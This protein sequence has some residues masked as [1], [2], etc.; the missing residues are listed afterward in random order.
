MK[1]LQIYKDYYPVLGGIENHLRVLCEGLCARGHEVTALVTSPGR[2]TTIAQHGQLRIVRA[3]RLL[4]AASTPL[5]L[6]MLREALQAP[7]D[8]VHLHYP[9]PPGDLA[10]LLRPALPLVVTYHSDIVR[11]QRLDRAYAPLRA[12][13][14]RRAQAI[15]ATNAP[16]IASSPVL[17]PLAHKCRVVPLSV[18]A[19]RFATPNLELV[20][21]LRARTAGPVVLFVGRL[22]YYKGL[23]FALEALREVPGTLL[24]V[25]SGGE[26]PRLR[27][28]AAELGIASRVVFA[29]DVDDEELP[30]YYAAA[31]LFVL[32]A[33]LRAEAFGTVL[34]EAMATGLPLLTTELGTGTS[35]VN[36]HGV[37][38]FVVPP[39]DSAALARA[40]AVLLANPSLRAAFGA[41]GKARAA[42][43]FS[44][45]QLIASIEQV[46]C[47][48]LGRQ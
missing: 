5:S 7:A 39:A 42:T 35:Y 41:A 19:G 4:Q 37:T 34:L 11:Q 47:E 46:Y 26:E 3:G 10:A 21:T 24:L 9:F 17:R 8:L 15:L 43:M 38:G 18:D 40:M 36:Q 22:R 1:I 45:E 6:A 31:D 30:S 16:Y 29:G 44:P 25:G 20:A 13:T 27:Q 23:H 32:P 48:A 14:L 2:H 33:H 28:L 12:L